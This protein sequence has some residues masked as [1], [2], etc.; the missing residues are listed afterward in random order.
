M[1]KATQTEEV[2]ESRC[3]S[4]LSP[5]PGHPDT[6]CPVPCGAASSGVPAHSLHLLLLHPQLGVSIYLGFMS[7]A[8]DFWLLLSQMFSPGPPVLTICPG[9]DRHRVQTCSFQ[10]F[11]LV[12]VHIHIHLGLEKKPKCDGMRFL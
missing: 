7:P 4:P 11:S 12:F 3:N 10:S 6:R 8:Q 5:K 1:L 9:S 2:M